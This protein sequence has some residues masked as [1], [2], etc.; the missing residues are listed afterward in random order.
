[1]KDCKTYINNSYGNE[2]LKNRQFKASSSSQ[3]AHEAIRPTD[4]NILNTDDENNKVYQIIWK[5]A[6]ASQMSNEKFNVITLEI[7]NKNYSEIFVSRIE[8]CIFDG[9]MI[10][11]SKTNNKELVSFY[12]SLNINE[13]INYNEI[14]AEQ[15]YKKLPERYSESTL[16]KDLEKKGIGRPSTYASLIDKVQNRN[17]VIKSNIKGENKSVINYLINNL[18]DK[19]IEE[20]NKINLNES[21]NRIIPTD[22]GIKVNNYLTKYFSDIILNYDF[23]SKLEKNLDLVLQGKQDYK[24]LLENFYKEFFIIYNN[25]IMQ[26]SSKNFDNGRFIGNHPE[27]NEPIYVRVAKYGPVAQIGEYAKN[28]KIYYIKLSGYNLDT[29]KLED[30]LEKMKYPKYLG[31]YNGNKIEL[32]ERKFGFCIV[33]NGDCYSLYQNEK[34]NLDKID[35]DKAIEVIQRKTRKKPLKVLMNGRAELL[36]GPYGKYVRY[37][38]TNGEQ[39]NI[40]IPKD[41]D[42]NIVDDNYIQTILR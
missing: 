27:S 20:K 36:E 42:I 13:E 24:K 22:L 21:K 1:M 32:A 4:I 33:Y 34:D 16:I 38:K 17:Y 3:E 6:L 35:K 18:S 37:V 15:K 10:L 12:K 29:I 19:I 28:K 2:Y 31:D 9:Y 11:Y 39:I 14:K 25:L 40:S 5:R 23:T 30:V 41:I 26:Q 8:D 7:S